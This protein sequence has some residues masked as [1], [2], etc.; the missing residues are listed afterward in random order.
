MRFL[1]F[2]SEDYAKLLEERDALQQQVRALELE[3]ASRPKGP[4]CYNAGKNIDF[5]FNFN[6]PQ[7]RVFS[8]E[9][10]LRQ[11]NGIS[12][13]VWTT[14]IGYYRVDEVGQNIQ[15]PKDEEGHSRIRSWSF[16]CDDEA[17][18]KL[19][20]EWKESLNKS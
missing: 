14:E 5:A 6:D 8:I 2:F 4:I 9:R 10:N 17:H 7:I 18:N 15:S 20:R 19:V 1:R 13:L 12:G 11:W 3:L 16:I